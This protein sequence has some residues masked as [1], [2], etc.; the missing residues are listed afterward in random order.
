V[1]AELRVMLRIDP[2]GY[3]LCYIGCFSTLC[4]KDR[5]EETGKAYRR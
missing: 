3:L 2:E 4:A 1:H 5:R